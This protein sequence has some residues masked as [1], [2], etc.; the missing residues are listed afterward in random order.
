M[1]ENY[2][3][4]KIYLLLLTALLVAGCDKGTSQLQKITEIEVVGDNDPQLALMML[5]SIK[6]SARKCSEYVQKRYDL[7]EI[8]LKDKAY[9]PVNSDIMVRELVEY[10]D[11][12][13][14][15]HDKQEAHY[16]AGSVYR[17]IDDAPRAIDHFLKARDIALNNVGCDSTMLR[18]TYSNLHYIYNNVQDYQNALTM[19]ENELECSKRFKD[20]TATDY[21]HVGAALKALDRTHEAVEYFDKAYHVVTTGNTRTKDEVTTLLYHYT[22]IKNKERAQKCFELIDKEDGKSLTSDEALSLAEYML[23]ANH[24]DSAEMYLKRILDDNTYPLSVKYDAAHRLLLVNIDISTRDTLAKYAVRFID[25][26]DSLNL[27]T[28]QV[29]A[30]TVNN[31]YKYNR[32][33]EAEEEMRAKQEMYKRLAIGVVL[34]TFLV[35]AILLMMYFRSKYNTV[36]TLL[37]KDV[38]LNNLK[39]AHIEMMGK[40]QGK[41]EELNSSRS[42]LDSKTEQLQ[43]INAEIDRFKEE[44]N[45]KKEEMTRMQIEL[46]EK[47]KQNELLLRSL[48]TFALAQD[49]EDVKNKIDLAIR[50]RYSLQDADWGS[51]YQAVDRQNPSFIQELAEKLGT[52]D[53]KQ[54]QFCYLIKM[55]LS[56]GQIENI[57]DVSHATIWR[58][59]NKYRDLLGLR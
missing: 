31:K 5:D 57:L 34:G 26:S 2:R 16:Y 42:L 14:S 36:R 21:I 13:G 28:R 25:I 9:I 49:A 38:E 23:L 7:L 59:S 44:V 50:G 1:T 29:A 12:N 10:F 33:A 45:S 51:L 47:V 19:A 3:M 32:D 48:H 22:R 53:E 52:F 46:E 6:P 4:R 39:K 40:I 11:D 56:N 18:N 24:P 30:A 8:R 41:E 35:I 15:N 37:S 27:G 55:G 54:K 43:Q 17:D 58:W 20:I